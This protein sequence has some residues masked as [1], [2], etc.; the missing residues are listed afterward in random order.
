MAYALM[1]PEAKRGRPNNVDSNQHLDD[2]PDVDKATISRARYIFRHDPDKARLVRD[3]HP[4]YRNF[5]MPLSLS[6]L[7]SRALT[8]QRDSCT[9]PL[10]EHLPE[11]AVSK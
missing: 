9:L 6:N 7:V 11:S 2:R 1:W 10:A 5:R 3:G 4:D 8:R